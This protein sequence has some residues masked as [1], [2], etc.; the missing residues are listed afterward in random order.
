MHGW[1]APMLHHR[2]N[3]LNVYSRKLTASRITYI[4]ISL[5]NRFT[6][7]RILLDWLDEHTRLAFAR[8]NFS[9]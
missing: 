3:M 8:H 4:W 6:Y 7:G 5:L 2:T 9:Y 1:C